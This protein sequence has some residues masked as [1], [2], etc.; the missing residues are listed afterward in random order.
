MTYC[1]EHLQDE[2][3]GQ[4][5]VLGLNCGTLQLPPEDGLVFVLF[6]LFGLFVYV[7]SCGGGCKGKRK[8][9]EIG[10]NSGKGQHIGA[11]FAGMGMG[12]P[13]L[14]SWE[15]ESGPFPG[16][17]RWP[18]QSCSGDLT[19]VVQ[20]IENLQTDQLSDHP[21]P[22]PVLGNVPTQNLHHLW[23]NC[24]GLWKGQSC[25][26]KAIRCPWDRETIG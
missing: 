20:I 5:Y 17:F 18:I 12:E 6:S 19:L 1:I 16:S 13:V 15:Q 23:S 8:I 4:W 26:C 14:R 11:G 7:L 21:G 24:W 25:S 10:E 2:M 22:D 9:W 3:H